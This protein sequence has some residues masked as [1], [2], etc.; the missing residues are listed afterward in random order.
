MKEGLVVVRE[1]AQHRRADLRPRGG[2][3]VNEGGLAAGKRAQARAAESW[4]S[5]QS[6]T[7]NAT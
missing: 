1:T 2:A 4:L 6:T 3:G 7:L 5:Q